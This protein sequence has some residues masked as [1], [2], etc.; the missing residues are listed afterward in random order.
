VKSVRRR[1]QF[2][3]LGAVAALAIAMVAIMQSPVGATTQQ[4]QPAVTSTITVVANGLNAPR[5]LVYDSAMRRVLVAE[6]GIQAQ[7]TGPCGEAER[8]LPFCL[9]LTGSI[10]QYNESDGSTQRIVTGLPSAGLQLPLSVV[11]GLHDVIL[12]GEEIV[13]AF[14]LLGNQDY[15]TSLGPD[16]ANMG[17]V[18]TIN[19][20]GKVKPMADIVGFEDQFYADRPEAD[21]YG[22]AVGSY[23][24]MLANAGGP[25]SEGNDLLLISPSGVITQVAQFPERAPGANPSDTVESVPT[26]V[27][28]GP[29]GAFY[30]GELT[31]APFYPGEARVWR[32][33]PGQAPTIYAQGM[34]LI[35]DMAVDEQGRLLV[36]ETAQ[37]NPFDTTQ[38]G[39]LL[40]IEPNGDKTVLASAGMKNPG[41]IA[42][43]GPGLYYVT[44]GNA[45]GGG[46]GQLLRIQVTG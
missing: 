15:R 1:G 38:D 46:E 27:V 41:G 14:G 10:L 32:V 17:S 30:V 20:S 7:D 31:G 29:D 40:R 6:A 44:A 19:G 35:I 42:V 28:Q 22:L 3:V 36:L 12:R 37:D 21:P 11:I 4:S 39:T 2:A 24:T 18:V 34:T 5:G 26:C 25:H 33:V 8:G 16:A 9:G 13:A 23:G 43:A 45:S